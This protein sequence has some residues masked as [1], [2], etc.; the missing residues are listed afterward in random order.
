M[1]KELPVNLKEAVL[2]ERVAKW[3]SEFVERRGNGKEREER[4]MKWRELREIVS[5]GYLGHHSP[6]FFHHALIWPFSGG[7]TGG[8]FLDRSAARFV[9][10]GQWDDVNG[11][12]EGGSTGCGQATTTTRWWRW[13]ARLQPR[14]MATPGR[15]RTDRRPWQRRFGWEREREKDGGARMRPTVKKIPRAAAG[16]FIRRRFRRRVRHEGEGGDS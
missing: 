9:R 12:D 3:E 4:A 1:G 13:A 11:G 8:G 7:G 16:V 2:V 15:W 5:V 6:Q 14:M 10:G